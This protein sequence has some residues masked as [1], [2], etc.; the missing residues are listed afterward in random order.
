MACKVRR[1]KSIIAEVKTDND[2][3]SKL[4]EDIASKVK[5]LDEPQL[6]ELQTRLR[7]WL[8]RYINNLSEGDLALGL[9]KQAFSDNFTKFFGDWQNNKKLPDLDVNG[10]P[11]FNTSVE[12]YLFEGNGKPS[13]D[14]QPED[15]PIYSRQTTT[16]QTTALR[17]VEGMTTKQPTTSSRE[18]QENVI[19]SLHSLENQQR[20]S[21]ISSINTHRPEIHKLLSEMIDKDGHLNTNANNNHTDTRFAQLKDRLAFYPENA[22]F[23]VNQTIGSDN[24][25][26]SSDPDL[27]VI[28][29]R[30]GQPAIDYYDFYELEGGGKKTNTPW[31]LERTLQTKLTNT[32]DIL[33]AQGVN[34]NSIIRMEAVPIIKDAPDYYRIG[35]ADTVNETV[36]NL[37]P[38]TIRQ[39]LTGDS[40]I[41]NLISD[42]YSQKE[43]GDYSSTLR[44]AIQFL[45]TQYSAKPLI[46]QAGIA[47]EQA[48]SI[49]EQWSRDFKDADFKTTD[50]SD[51]N[52]YIKS[53]TDQMD[54][55]RLF[56][57]YAEDLRERSNELGLTDNQ[58]DYNVGES[59]KRYAELFR[60]AKEFN[61]KFSE[62]RGVDSIADPEAVVSAMVTQ[63]TDNN[64]VTTASMQTLSKIVMNSYLDSNK[65]A[66]VVDKALLKVRSVAIKKYGSEQN[67]RDLIYDEKA[68]KLIDRVDPKFKTALD[69][70]IQ[71]K[72]GNWIQKNID[73]KEYEA[74]IKRYKKEAEFQASQIND[75]VRQVEE[76]ARIDRAFDLSTPNSEGWFKEGTLLQNPQMDIWK[77]AEL[78]RLELPENKEALDAYNVMRD[79]NNM[80]KETGYL[81]NHIDPDTFVPWAGSSFLELVARGKNFF[82]AASDSWMKAF[83]V[84]D[85]QVG[86][87][88][89]DPNTG[90]PIETLPKYMVSK[91]ENP[92]SDIFASYAQFAKFVELHNE[93]SKVENIVRN[94]SRIERAKGSL[95]T[96]NFGRLSKSGETSA[97]NKRNADLLDNMISALVYGHRDVSDRQL[98]IY[99][100]KVPESLKKINQKLNFEL[101][102]E[103]YIGNAISFSRSMDALISYTQT[104]VLSFNPLSSLSNLLGGHYQAM[105]NAGTYFTK[106]DFVSAEFSLASHGKMAQGDKEFLKAAIDYFLIG[107]HLDPTHKYIKKFKNGISSE[108]ISDVLAAGLRSG[109]IAVKLA[110]G[111]AMINNMIVV[112]GKIQNA[113]DYL[114]NTPEYKER[115]GKSEAERKAIEA[116]FDAEVNNLIATKGIRNNSKIVDGELIINGVD[117]F[118]QSVNKQIAIYQ[119]LVEKAIGQLSEYQRRGINLH[120]I[121]RAAMLF[122]NWIPSLYDQRFGDLKFNSATDKMEWGRMRTA[123]K[124]LGTET[125]NRVGEFISTIKA[126]DKG[127]K[128]LDKFYAETQANYEK[129]TGKTFK[130]S[131]PEFYDM[132]RDN[133]KTTAYDTLAALTLMGT[134]VTLS[135]LNTDDTVHG[136]HASNSYKF[137]MKALDK[138]KDEVTYFYDPRNMIQ[139]LGTSIF[140]A[141]RT[142]QQFLQVGIHTFEKGLGLTFTD[143]KMVDNIHLAKDY[144]KLVPGLSQLTTLTPLFMDQM[145]KDLDIRITPNQNFTY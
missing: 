7:P 42:L 121:G 75:P 105:I 83:T 131:K 72:D 61:T 115:Y 133:L 111:K 87:G 85:E 46:Y 114:R 117:R 48:K 1:V 27:M 14:L 119:D 100:G 50:I 140:P 56:T 63:F 54:N 145:A 38:V 91:I 112:D 25:G 67:F 55:L 31:Y 81:P 132:V 5:S 34:P 28:Y 141:A 59:N 101:F 129:K 84:N 16:G 98:D 11:L 9:Y 107:E 78:K 96:D 45:Q 26:K 64:K 126:T 123:W 47:R 143:G 79:Y 108:V 135:A 8:G 18:S 130:M 35:I 20:E 122:K 106:G 69:T 4:Y 80:A 37:L 68:H 99:L 92:S 40:V 23:K 127:L 109:D 71:N 77:S 53:V 58:I 137:F 57:K 3:D 89:L 36:P 86:Y 2:K 93:M 103:K 70:A 144:M 24:L 17:S 22:V 116:S 39:Q 88:Q 52:N 6:K 90:K 10:E 29:D 139:L 13:I 44:K 33:I 76:L 49:A 51:L 60:V 21:A 94:M 102:N 12:Q 118:D 120:A 124:F 74:T 128:N 110:T 136:H 19:N 97:E 104:K 32:R 65:R 43:K 15:R 125:F 138:A 142:A 66:Q 82:Q 73:T 113:R 41:D 134:F 95:A 30:D 62:S